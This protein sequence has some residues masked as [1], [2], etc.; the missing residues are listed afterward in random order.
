MPIGWKFAQSNLMKPTADHTSTGSIS[1]AVE[2]RRI[3]ALLAER[4][5]MR[6]DIRQL[7]AA[8]QVYAESVRRMESRASRRAA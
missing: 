5:A 6:E 4:E 1:M 3:T 2:H 7:S 8:V